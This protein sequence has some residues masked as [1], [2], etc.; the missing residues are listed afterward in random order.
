MEK[1]L[2]RYIENFVKSKMRKLNPFGK[3]FRLKTVG[4]LFC[5]IGIVVNQELATAFSFFTFLTANPSIILGGK[6]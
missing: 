3:I 2:F 4:C 5:I 6:F 1:S